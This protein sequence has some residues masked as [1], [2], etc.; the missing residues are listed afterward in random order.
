MK[1][2]NSTSWAMV[3]QSVR[4]RRRTE[5][6]G[7]CLLQRTCAAP[8]LFAGTKLTVNVPYVQRKPPPCCQWQRFTV[9]HR[10]QQT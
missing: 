7:A 1:E 4:R 6:L 8:K 9:I 3:F 5:A 10:H 2:S